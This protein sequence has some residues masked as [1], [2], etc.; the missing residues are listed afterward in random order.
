MVKNYCTT[1][2]LSKSKTSFIVI[3]IAFFTEYPLLFL[4]HISKYLP[5][6]KI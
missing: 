4:R 1:F 3:S 6:E 2:I 5:D